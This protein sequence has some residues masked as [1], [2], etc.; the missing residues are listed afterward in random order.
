MSKVLK[1]LYDQTDITKMIFSAVLN[2]L[3]LKKHLKNIVKE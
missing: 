3:E 1:S 2:P